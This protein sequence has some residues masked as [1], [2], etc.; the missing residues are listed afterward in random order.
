[1]SMHWPS[2]DEWFASLTT[3]DQDRT[4]ALVE[5]FRSV[6][7]EDPEGWARSQI[8]ENIAQLARFLVLRRVRKLCLEKWMR[9]DLDKLARYDED[10]QDLLERLRAAGLKDAEIAQFA[11]KVAA[12]AAWDVVEVI[13][14][15]HDPD[16]PATMPGW[17]LE[18][19]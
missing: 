9:F 10:F 8:S 18:E 1:M 15:G 19:S 11:Q 16:A 12:I 7:T 4:R 13:D 14:E 6:G 17:S 5:E 3:D 2:F